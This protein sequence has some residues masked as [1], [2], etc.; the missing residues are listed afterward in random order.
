MLS[1]IVEFPVTSFEPGSQ[2]PLCFPFGITTPFDHN[3]VVLT[4][5][6]WVNKNFSSVNTC[7]W[8]GY[9]SLLP[10]TTVFKTPILNWIWQNW[11]FMWYYIEWLCIQNHSLEMIF[12]DPSKWSSKHISQWLEWA[13]QE[14][15]LDAIDVSK[16][17]LSGSQLLT[18]SK[19]EFLER[20]PPYTGDVLYAHLKLL[21]ARSGK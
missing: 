21:Q 17:Q 14:F 20:T 7:H 4:E 5:D 8:M 10:R 3:R 13:T 12:T 19:E 9:T 15:G 2:L 18:L 16:F 1:G 6:N 11:N